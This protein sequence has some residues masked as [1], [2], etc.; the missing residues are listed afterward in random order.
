[1]NQPAMYA[2]R[3]QAQAG[4]TLI[5]L[6]VVI[7]I[8]GILAATAL[9]KFASLGGDA[10]SASLNAV[11][12]ALNTTVSMMHGQYLLN[13][14][15]P[16]VNEGTTIAAVFGYP[17]GDTNTATAAGVTAADYQITANATASAVPAVAATHIPAI[18]AN[19]FVAVPKSVQGTAIAE[20][21]FASYAAAVN[22][23]TPPV[24][25]VTSSTCQ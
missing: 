6:I 20:T 2:I 18:P 7:V 10:R 17:A 23:T 8:L 4:F 25:E 19:G 15:G 21:C 9:P 1:M 24:V 11:K 16:F 5:E 12:G 3:R 14:A 22:A 13:P